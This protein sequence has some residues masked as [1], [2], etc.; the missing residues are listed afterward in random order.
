MHAYVHAYVC[1]YLV[2][3]CMCVHVCSRCFAYIPH[4][5]HTHDPHQSLQSK[6]ASAMLL[7][8]VGKQPYLMV[9]SFDNT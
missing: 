7:T 4:R 5:D 8:M 3:V 2:D 9:G 6:H 1:V